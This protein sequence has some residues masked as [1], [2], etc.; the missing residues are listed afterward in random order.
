[1]ETRHRV[2]RVSRVAPNARALGSLSEHHGANARAIDGAEAL[3]KRKISSRGTDASSVGVA[4]RELSGGGDV[5]GARVD[6]G[7]TC[8]DCGTTTTSRWRRAEEA[9]GG[10]TMVCKAC[11]QKRTRRKNASGGVG[12]GRRCVDCTS[13]VSRG[14]WV[15]AKS[16]AF[17]LEEEVG[18][19]CARCYERRRR[20]KRKLEGQELTCPKCAASKKGMLFY[21]NPDATTAEAFPKVCMMCYQ[22]TKYLEQLATRA[23]ATCGTSNVEKTKWRRLAFPSHAIDDTFS[24]DGTSSRRR[25]PRHSWACPTC[26][27]EHARAKVESTQA[28]NG[29]RGMTQKYGPSNATVQVC[30]IC[31]VEKSSGQWRKVNDSIACSACYQQAWRRNARRK[32]VDFI[33]DENPTSGWT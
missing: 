16:A 17:G 8:G 27:V 6:G 19:W 7:V 13:D 18:F 4:S 10:T 1:M 28:P 20:E 5:N 31:R 25:R 29:T 15:R 23:C 3:G 26:F 2:G 32:G 33:S 30:G 12:D 21:T 22:R 14:D 11:F 24:A 9:A